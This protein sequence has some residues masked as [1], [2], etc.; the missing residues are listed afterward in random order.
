MAPATRRG[1]A[2]KRLQQMVET[3]AAGRSLPR[4]TGVTPWRAS[5]MV[6]LK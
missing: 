6:T 3:M 1:Q 4:V 2:Q 5:S